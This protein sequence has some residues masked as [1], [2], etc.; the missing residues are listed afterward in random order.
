M[1]AGLQSKCLVA[2]VGATG[3]GKTALAVSL[4]RHFGC[5]I[6]SADARQVYK[7][8]SLGTAAP[9]Q[10]SQRQVRHHFIENYDTKTRVSAGRFARE[11]QVVLKKLF[12]R[13]NK[14]LLVGGSGL[15]VQAVCEGLPSWPAIPSEVRRRWRLAAE[16]SE[17]RDRLRCFLQAQDPDYVVRADMHNWHRL[18]RAAEVIEVT[19]KPYSQFKR[20][21]AEPDFSV[22]KLGLHMPRQQLYARLDQRVEQML[23]RGLEQEAQRLFQEKKCLPPTIGYQEWTDYFEHRCVREEVI[24]H[25][26]RNTRAYAKRQQ[27]WFKRDKHTQW[28]LHPYAV[29]EVIDYVSSRWRAVE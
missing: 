6:V 29:E 21:R 27:T 20:H 7:D 9:S 22:I 17:G 12:R 3:T 28:F 10:D 18:C 11:A 24:Q 5:E 14:V 13:H 19:Q 8:L 26:K 23:S 15:Y 2:I 1:I 25:I 4:A 16:T